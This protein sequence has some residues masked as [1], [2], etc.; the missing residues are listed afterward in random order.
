MTIGPSTRVLV[1]TIAFVAFT[2][3]A[4]AQVAPATSASPATPA[5]AATASI[6]GRVVDE[7]S[8]PLAG[9][10][11]TLTGPGPRRSET[12][13]ENG[14][15]QFLDLASGRY[16]LGTNKRSYTSLEKNRRNAGQRHTVQY[17]IG[18]ASVAVAMGEAIGD[19]EF[20][21]TRTGVI[22]VHVLDDLGYPRAGVDVAALSVGHSADGPVLTPVRISGDNVLRMLTG[23]RFTTD[24]RGIA[25]VY[26]LRPAEYAIVAT[27]RGG[28]LSEAIPH[29]V[30]RRLTPAYFPG[31]AVSRS[32]QFIALGPGEEV[33][34]T[35]SL[36]S[37]RLAS[38][39]G[40]AA[41]SDG[42][43]TKALVTLSMN[44]GVE[45]LSI[46][47]DQG[48]FTFWDIT[49]GDYKVCT[50]DI[51]DPPQEEDVCAD[52]FVAGEDITDVV[53]TTSPRAR[54]VTAPTR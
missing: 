5:T 15:Y 52:V 21:M 50:R 7:A 38:V 9:V 10:T 41:Q 40:R 34:V 30:E 53:L 25:R 4:R 13:G 12:T 35:V 33:H 6:A 19:V 24:D 23:Y 8:Q 36:M 42:S 54:D 22:V 29:D 18:G 47:T 27:P 45:D 17:F 32:A 3:T 14:V 48:N 39:S 1:A 49:P 37:G 26:G 44:R 2:S 11:V 16:G 43:A 46:E 28:V 51:G 31:V 20:V